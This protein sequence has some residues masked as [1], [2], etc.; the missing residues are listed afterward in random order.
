MDRGDCWATVRG[1]AESNM[2]EVTQQQQQR[3]AAEHPIT[4]RTVP[5]ARNYPAPNVNTTP[6]EKPCYDRILHNESEYVHWTTWM[7]VTENAHRLKG[8]RS[9]S[10]FM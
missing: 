1:V 6:V 9:T 2:I 3:D 4:H 10:P 5:T 7:N 8:P